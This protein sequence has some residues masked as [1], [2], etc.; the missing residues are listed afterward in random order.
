MSINESDHFQSKVAK[1][2]NDEA[3]S[4]L[5]LSFQAEGKVLYCHQVFLCNWSSVLRDAC[6]AHDSQQGQVRVPMSC[7]YEVAKTALRFCYS[8]QLQVSP[9]LLTKVHFFALKYDI[10]LLQRRCEGLLK[11]SVNTSNCLLFLSYLLDLPDGK[12]A[13]FDQ[14]VLERCQAL[15]VADFVEVR[16]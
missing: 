12:Q 6:E 9:G 16:V 14:D 8:G 1:W 2:F 5:H 15:A 10:A 4:D 13:V 11:D 3:Y 7:S